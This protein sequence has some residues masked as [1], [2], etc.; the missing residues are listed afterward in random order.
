[1]RLGRAA[2]AI[3]LPAL[4]I[5][6]LALARLAGG[7]IPGPELTLRVEVAQDGLTLTYTLHYDNVGV[8]EA[9]WVTVTDA[10]PA[11]STYL[12]PANDVVDGVWTQTYTH[13]G[14]GAHASTV[15][16]TLPEGTVDGQRVLNVVELRYP[17]ISGSWLTKSYAQEFGVRLPVGPGAATALPMWVVA[18]PV[19]AG[20]AL[21]GGVATVRAR[22]RPKIEQVFLMH[23]SGMLIQHWAANVSPS[24]DIDIL[25][26]M[27]VILKEF[28]RDSFREKAGG[29]TEFRFG[30]SRVFLAEGRFAILA[31]VVSG[32]HV[33]GLPAEIASA[34][35]DFER[36][37]G[38]SLAN[39][40]GQVE[41][42][43][44][45][46]GVVDGLVHGRYRAWRP[47]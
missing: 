15:A 42:L 28:V 11:G 37:H 23:H 3:C 24:R 30:D 14:P 5:A 22:R 46:R 8:L 17:D 31:A 35:Q 25:S 10:L 47:T 9:S 36:L 44:G 16:V 45:A 12:G 38:S 21:A 4:A 41:G 33:N 13:V 39:W 18:A 6:L 1:M 26:G 19:A 2:G 27:F 29:L 32:A 34:V 40:N 20:G 43:P 7:T